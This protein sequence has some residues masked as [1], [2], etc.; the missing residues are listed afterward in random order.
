MKSLAMLGLVLSYPLT[1]S[2]TPQAATFSY[3]A[4][5]GRA[6]ADMDTERVPEERGPTPEPVATNA[7]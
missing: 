6:L 5:L 3:S 7:G 4:A 1:F 2:A